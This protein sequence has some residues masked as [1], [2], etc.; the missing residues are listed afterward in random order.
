MSKRI[1]T[2]QQKWRI[3]K[4]QQERINR[5][6]KKAQLQNAF[7]DS[8][9]ENQSS[10][11]YHGLV[12]KNYGQ[13]LDVE[14]TSSNRL[15]MDGS[16][17][18]K[19][20][21]CSFRQN[22]GALVAGDRVLWHKIVQVS[23]N[24]NSSK[25]NLS[26]QVYEGVISALEE[27]VSLLARPD[28]YG[29]KKNIAANIEQILIIN[30]PNSLAL[31]SSINAR[32]PRLNTGLIDR[33]LVTA[34]SN[35]IQAVIVINKTDLLSDG[36]LTEIRAKL[37]VYQQLGYKIAYTSALTDRSVIEQLSP[38][39]EN[40]NSIF[41]GQSGVG[42]SSLLNVLLPNARAKTANVSTV[43]AKGRHTT[44][45]AQ[46]Y[47]LD[48]AGIINA[49]IIDSP[50]I[51]EFGLWDINNND[52]KNGFKEIKRFSQNCRFRDCK[53]ENEPNCAVLAAVDQGLISE[54]R[55]MSYQKIIQEC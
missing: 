21:R 54:N 28:P 7:V 9:S 39:L 34:E 33:Y 37:E 51:R 22:L 15:S 18:F 3:E 4:I 32:T 41:V 27:R 36:E 24:S 52:I 19:V 45:A 48:Q 1:L 8:S 35:H 43:N 10:E 50:G 11:Q 26:N 30:A 44:S 17:E 38:L 14:E 23:A 49:T 20:Y 31:D 16:Q 40:K 5:A 29:T 47:H 13:S 2:R 25:N 46:L 53:H 55:Y 42:K 6:N 12:I